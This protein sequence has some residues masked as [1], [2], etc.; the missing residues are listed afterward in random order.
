MSTNSTT[1]DTL[2]EAK[3]IEEILDAAEEPV[4]TAEEVAEELADAEPITLEEIFADEPEAPVEEAEDFAEELAEAVNA[5]EKEAKAATESDLAEEAMSAATT[6]KEEIAEAVEEAPKEAGTIEEL[7]SKETTELSNEEVAARIFALSD[8]ENDEEVAAQI[9]AGREIR[10]EAAN[11]EEAKEKKEQ[12]K[13]K[14]RNTLVT[15]GRLRKTKKKP[16]TAAELEE[17]AAAEAEAAAIREIVEEAAGEYEQRFTLDEYKEIKLAEFKEMKDMTDELN[18]SDDPH[19]L[20]RDMRPVTDLKHMLETTTELYGD[21]PFFMQKEDK[22]G[23]FKEITYKEALADVNALGTALINLGLKDK[24]IGVIGRNCYQWAESYLAV[25]CGTG[26]VVP[27]DK[28]LNSD[29][30]EQLSVKGEL[31]AVITCDN[32]YYEIFKNIK[33]NGKTDI[34]F[35][36]NADMKADENTAAGLLSWYK[37]R[38]YGRELVAGGDKRFINAQIVNTELAVILFTSGTTGVSKGVM[39]SH[40]N[41][42]ADC[43]I[44]PHLLE[45][46]PGDRFFMILPIHH[47][48][49]STASF[50]VPMY[51]GS[52]IVFCSGLKYLVKEM[53]ES[54][55]QLLLGVPVIFENFYNKIKRSV[56]EQGKEKL[57]NTVLKINGYTQKVG[58]N[59]AKGA[60]KQILDTFGGEM[61]TLIT[62]GAPIDGDIMDFFTD[63]GLR[64]VQGYGLTESSPIVA[65]NPDQKK[66]MRNYA[67]GYVLPRVECKIIDKDEDGVGEI[68]FKGPIIML[69]YYKDEDN[70]E[71]V[72]RDGWFHTGDLG[73]LDDDNYV[74]ITGRKKNVIITGNGKNVF[75]EELEFY[76]TKSAYI[77][78]A[79]VWGDEDND[80]PLKRGIYV[81]V[82]VNKEAVEEALG[83]DATDEQIYELVQREI[84]KINA[85]LPLFKKI[86][87]II[88][89][90]RE[91]DKTTALKIRRFV[92]DNKYE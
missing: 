5:A 16:V 60:T 64:A 83:K 78:E 1:K 65:L 12:L 24:K 10:K 62:G 85:D 69:G 7:F 20:Y 31:S 44:A 75:P 45:V 23:E 14:F 71:A 82:R 90:K 91:F 57:L 34:E 32:K 30:L 74:V 86:A 40:K 88:V 22:H 76:A 73:Y 56:R 36:I 80:D 4:E 55:P 50:L 27:L 42:C 89:R 46:K 70:T 61:R 29:E 15:I 11:P 26:V 35:V 47:T 51:R 38:E 52:T 58:L 63:L 39:L 6:V 8:A 21:I 2:T 53:Q 41:L 59:I 68:C 79:F 13:K 17:Q 37:L 92:E 3:E 81:T 33:A 48:Y 25:I 28:E 72:L 67:A 54:K 19:I 84:D 43:I 9:E 77:D 49:A 18:N 66:F 87:H